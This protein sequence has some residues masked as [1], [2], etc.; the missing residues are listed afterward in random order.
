MTT[1]PPVFTA[2]KTGSSGSTPFFIVPAHPSVVAQ[3]TASGSGRSRTA[4]AA[5]H[6]REG[7]NVSHAQPPSKQQQRAAPTHTVTA[8]ALAPIIVDAAGSVSYKAPAHK[9]AHHLHSIPPREKTAKTL[10]LDHMLWQHIRA[11]FLQARS[12]LGLPPTLTPQQQQ[13][14][15]SS[16]SPT[17][18][19][20]PLQAHRASGASGDDSQPDLDDPGED[21]DIITEGHSY[22]PSSHAQPPQK[23]L[24]LS[25]EV[26]DDIRALKFGVRGIDR[27]KAYLEHHAEDDWYAARVDLD[28]ARVQR[29]TAEGMEKVM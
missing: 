7:N 13:S 5:H 19:T 11:R 26:E 1:E 29:A 25:K 24:R 9:H 18:S 23:R 6:N 21:E 14:L 3:S 22:A 28:T 8:P 16:S 2:G 27:I 4:A 12:E 17:I 20:S 15:Q 10:I